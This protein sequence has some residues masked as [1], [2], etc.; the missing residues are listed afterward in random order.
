MTPN[1]ILEKTELR[2]P[3]SV[4][5]REQILALE[6]VM[7]KYEQL[8]IEPVHY[9]YAGGYARE[10]TIPGGT[11][12]TGKEHKTEHLNIL[13][14]GSITVWTEDGMKRLTAPFTFVSRPGTKRVGLAHEDTVW[15][16]VHAN[17]DDLRDPEQLEELLILNPNN[18]LEGAKCLGS[19]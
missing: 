7:R 5:T 11:L 14:K 15:T 16:T 19:P 9:F 1:L 17:P 10:I 18:Q 6:D 8:K 3:P 4:P 12:L 2:S 13:S